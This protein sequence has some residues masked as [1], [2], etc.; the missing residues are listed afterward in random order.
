MKK[1]AIVLI[2]ALTLGS[3]TAAF[4]APAARRGSGGRGLCAAASA[5]P[6]A[7]DSGSGTKEIRVKAGYSRSE[8]GASRG[9]R[10]ARL[11]RGR[12]PLRPRRDR[13]LCP[14][15]SPSQ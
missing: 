7:V 12:S 2:T 3:M 10:C 11:T 8:T 5:A 13:S 4:A 15:S 1:C 6:A 9:G 14:V